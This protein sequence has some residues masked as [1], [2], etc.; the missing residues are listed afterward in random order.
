M[1]DDDAESFGIVDVAKAPLL[2][3]EHDAALVRAV[4][5]D[6][7]QHL[8]QRGLAGAVFADQRV[9]LPRL[10]GEIHVAQGLDSGEALADPAHLDNCRHRAIYPLCSAHS[11][12]RGNPGQQATEFAALD[13]RFRGDE[14]R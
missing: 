3:V 5:I 14:R 12:V 2:A 4:G 9:D 10:H 8:H 6:A 7:A 11:R 1:N 13:P